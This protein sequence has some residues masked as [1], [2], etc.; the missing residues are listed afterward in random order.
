MNGRREG[1]AT[2]N[3]SSP[4]SE[5]RLL[6]VAT[7][8]A[9][10]IG[11][12]GSINSP[13]PPAPPA[14]NVNTDVACPSIPDQATNICPR[15]K[16]ATLTCGGNGMLHTSV[17]G[18]SGSPILLG[19]KLDDGSVLSAVLVVV[20][21]QDGPREGVTFGVTYTG[22]VSQPTSGPPC[23]SQSKAVYSQFQFG[24]PLYAGFEG[25]AKDK[26]HRTL[27]DEAMVAFTTRLGIAQGSTSRCS[28]WRDM[29]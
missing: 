28:F 7:T 9:H 2:M 10:L 1:G 13:T 22:Q 6:F 29:P 11:C 3:R 15:L 26:L 12:T 4:P 8:L 21:C 23:I 14:N 20:N 25:L 18:G 16:N 5:I 17:G 19:A 27:D 24:N